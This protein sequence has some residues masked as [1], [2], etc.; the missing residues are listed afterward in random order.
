MIT[1]LHVVLG[2]LMP[3][4]LA[5]RRALGTTLF[6]ARPLTWF[7]TLL[8]P[9][10]VVLNGLANW[11]LKTLFKIDPIGE[12]GHMHSAEELRLLLMQTEQSEEVTETE[13]EILINALELN[14]RLARDVLT[15]RQ[16]VVTLD[17]NA[18]FSE[19]V[20]V[21]LDSRHTRFPLVD[22]HLD[23]PVG[24]IH[25][26]D[27]T[28]IL[29][30]ENPDLASIKRP[31]ISVSEL[32]HLDDLLMLFRRDRAHMALVLDE[33]GGSQG[34]VTMDNVIEELV[35]DIQDE[36]DKPED[37]REFFPIS[38]DEFVALGTMP[39]HD[40]AEHTGYEF[41]NPE[42]STVG[43]YVTHV[44]GHLPE[45]GE[46]VTVYDYEATVVETDGKSVGKLK[47]VRLQ[48]GTADTDG[49][50]G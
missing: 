14:D 39:L 48:P 4:S 21:A 1:I 17:V 8:K 50:E 6:T 11:L 38:D 32:M 9:A 27:L 25:I 35:G 16:D 30:E 10:I 43:G 36:F 20:K 45:R 22:G 41:E 29:G 3:K 26:K 28:R 33:R 7:H 46:R 5:I 2:E 37:E 44:L 42:V 23:E 34:I 19:N 49:V 24:L 31:L 47:F 18:T 12:H 15:S 13:R 40:L